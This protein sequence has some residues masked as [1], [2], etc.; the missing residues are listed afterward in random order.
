M[1]AS[2]IVIGLAVVTAFVIGRIA[3]LQRAIAEPP[4]QT[5]TVD[6]RLSAIEDRLGRIEGSL[7]ELLGRGQGDSIVFSEGSKSK[8]AL[9]SIAALLELLP[10][11]LRPSP[12]QWTDSV[13]TAKASAW[14][15]AHVV[16]RR[17]VAEVQAGIIS[18]ASASLQEGGAHIA[19][20]FNY[21]W[22]P[23]EALG[24]KEV[25]AANW[26]ATSPQTHTVSLSESDARKLIALSGNSIRIEGTVLRAGLF[27]GSNGKPSYS[28]TIAEHDV[29]W[30]R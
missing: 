9:P 21:E 1:R 12:D 23:V 20:E 22:Q 5:L 8:P 30:I 3:P 17:V 24:F 14:Y 2:S 6:Q 15:A 11:E 16:G 7:K 13:T 10:K 26:N 4:S 29:Q 18:A 19:V 27:I 25:R 28:L